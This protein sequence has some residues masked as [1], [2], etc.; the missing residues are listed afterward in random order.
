MT[1]I[2]EQDYVEPSRPLSQKELQYMRTGLYK[3][4]RL[5]KTKAHHQ[6]CNHFYLVKMNGRK[7]KDMSE[8]KS[9]DTGNCSV[10]WKISKTPQRLRGVARNMCNSYFSTFENEPKLLSHRKVDLENVFYKWLY[11][12]YN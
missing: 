3:N 4:L 7:E 12:E 9:N 10:C 5:G 1:S 8:Q 11:E 2:L 6:R